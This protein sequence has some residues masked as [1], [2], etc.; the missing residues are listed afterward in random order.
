MIHSITVG[1]VS[2]IPALRSDPMYKRLLA[3]HK[4]NMQ[5]GCSRSVK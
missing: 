3:S 2:M 5:T 4:T 1:V